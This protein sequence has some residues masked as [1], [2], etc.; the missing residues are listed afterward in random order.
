MFARMPR[1]CSTRARSCGFMPP[2]SSAC[3]NEVRASS[4]DPVARSSPP[5]VLSA[6]AAR[7]SYAVFCL[8]KKN[9]GGAERRRGQHA[10]RARED[11]GLVRPDVAEG[12]LRHERVLVG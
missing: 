1:F 6:S 8:K 2:S 11:G 9:G 4:M 10:H 7:I 12:V 5:R 3:R